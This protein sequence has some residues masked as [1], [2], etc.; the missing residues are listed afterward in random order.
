MAIEKH[1]YAPII[2]ASI[3]VLII[4]AYIVFSIYL[5]ITGPDDNPMGIFALP[6]I[7]IGVLFSYHTIVAYGFWIS[8]ISIVLFFISLPICS[9]VEDK[10]FNKKYRQNSQVIYKQKYG[11][12][13]NTWKDNK[14]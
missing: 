9:S 2:F 4:A 13:Y 5:T 12:S 6:I 8:L 7:M 14:D 10:N 3:P 11:K 1:L